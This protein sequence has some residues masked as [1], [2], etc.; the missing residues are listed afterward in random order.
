MGFITLIDSVPKLN[1]AIYVKLWK[2]L[3]QVNDIYTRDNIVHGRVSEE[4][5]WFVFIYDV[6][7]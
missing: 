2:I 6:K 7:V 5:I 1:Y 3:T 4:N